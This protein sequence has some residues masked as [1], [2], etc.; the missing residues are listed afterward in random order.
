MSEQ[1]IK[2]GETEKLKLFKNSKGY[3]WEIVINEVNI[4]RL[5]ELNNQMDQTFGG[6]VE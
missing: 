1:P 4:E 6:S 2:T 3:N 5:A